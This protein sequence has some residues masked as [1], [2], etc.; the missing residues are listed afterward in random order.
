MLPHQL[1]LT[2][3]VSDL[4]PAGWQESIAALARTSGR[5]IRREQAD[6]YSLEDGGLKYVVVDGPT[7]AEKLPWLVEFFRHP[8]LTMLANKVA[9][10]PV[11]PG[12]DLLTCLNINLLDGRGEK[13]EKHYDPQPF[14][15]VVFVNTLLPGD[16]G[17]LELWTRDGQGHEVLVR[18]VAGH[19]IVFD[20]SKTP[21]RVRPLIADVPRL[22]IVMEFW[23]EGAGLD[24]ARAE[25]TKYL[26][27]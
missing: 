1:L 17:E 6:R 4:L 7:I 20:G 27:E 8:K 5:Q 2:T 11:V 25:N 3:D 16:G 26:Y 22:T 21:H 9:G 15:M 14:T 10:E 18:P 13:Y 24:P 23:R 19:A 12:S